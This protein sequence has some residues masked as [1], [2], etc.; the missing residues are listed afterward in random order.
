MEL[1]TRRTLR[2]D[3]LTPAEVS[4]ISCAQT[5]AWWDRMQ[6]GSFGPTVSTIMSDDADRAVR[7]EVIYQLLSGHDELSLDS[8][9]KPAAVRALRMVGAVIVGQLDLRHLSARC[10]LELVSCHFQT[11]TGPVLL[12]GASFP[13]LVIRHCNIPGLSGDGLRVRG[14]LMM[15]GLVSRE[16]VTLQGAEVSGTLNMQGAML[17]TSGSTALSADGI[18]IGGHLLANAGFKA[19]GLI[20]IINASIGSQLN[21]DGAQLSNPGAVAL[22]GE[23]IKTG[24]FILM[25]SN[26]AVEGC[27]VLLNASVGGGLVLD[28]AHLRNPGRDTVDLS[29]ATIA[30]DLRTGAGF[31]SE[32]TIKLIGTTVNGTVNLSGGTIIAPG[33]AAFFGDRARIRGS[34]FGRADFVTEGCI[35]L[36]E[37]VIDMELDLG[38]ATLRNA[39]GSALLATRANIGG[40]V[41]LRSNTDA[42]GQ[43][44]LSHS[45][46]AG[47]VFINQVQ[48]KNADSR[49]L[50]LE[51]AVLKSS[52]VLK[53]DLIEG[54]IDLTGAST[55]EY[56]DNENARQA[57]ARLAGFKY[58]SIRPEPPAISV[59]KRL[60]WLGADPDGYGPSSYTQLA[61]AMRK[62]GH[63]TEAKRVLVESQRRRWRRPGPLRLIYA[64]WSGVLRFTFGYGYRPWLVLAWLTAV[65]V[66]GSSY[67]NAVGKSAFTQT[68]GAPPF[69][70]MLYTVDTLLPFVDLGYNK[71]VPEGATHAVSSLV[72]IMGWL[73]ASALV[74]ALAGLFRRGD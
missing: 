5:G 23:G 57:P 15:R 67:F 25:R 47:P 68:N 63:T 48:L 30:G 4:L 56:I 18:N 72:V 69:N 6:D 53:P 49:V 59:S 27:V 22:L 26:F 58:D 43:I 8:T 45:T 44:D 28:T 7:S 14:D 33:E 55:T 50:N 70:G 11:Q 36:I 9:D 74:A 62:R 41:H 40:A 60:K 24:G 20:E 73:L 38:G 3:E 32:G 1:S 52:L 66:A 54:L 2:V 34:F 31:Y 35:R 71:W 17:G 19:T 65:I 21:M 29:L 51:Y 10:P 46:I 12:E 39:G 42:T 16:P 13:Y 37:A 61:E 64:F